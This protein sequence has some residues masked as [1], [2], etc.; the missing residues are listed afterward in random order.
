[1]NLNQEKKD[2]KEMETKANV[3]KNEKIEDQSDKIFIKGS[4]NGNFINE[5]KSI[6]Y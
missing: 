6:I 3:F 2:Q 4:K 1:M 5:I